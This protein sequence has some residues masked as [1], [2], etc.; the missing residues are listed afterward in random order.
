MAIKTPTAELQGLFDR[1]VGPF[2]ESV[3]ALIEAVVRRD[4]LAQARAEAGLSILFR[5]SGMLADAFGR[6]RIVLETEKATANREVIRS[7]AGEA[8]L[9]YVETP[10][11]PNVPFEEAFDDIFTRQPIG[12]ANKEDV[13]LA[14]NEEHG[15]ALSQRTSGRIT[16]RV[17]GFF[18]SQRR[19]GIVAPDAITT[20]A[21]LGNFSQAY[22]Q[23]V[24]RTTMSQAYTAGRFRQAADPDIAEV[25]PG[26]E[27]DAVND[28]D[29]RRGRKVD[30]YAAGL[31]ENHRALDK[32]V[33]SIA[34]RI[35]LIYAPPNGY[36]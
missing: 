21:E 27:Y 11:V 35:W 9:L 20:L 16:E 28:S 22:A 7:S 18:E 36:T 4:P 25:M 2:V 3:D 31:A 6:R 32:L 12:N 13:Q 17:Q 34:S 1:N 29:L 33:A 26:F 8:D 15:F 30:Q 14:Y 10:I 23:T 19:K 5:Q 24:F